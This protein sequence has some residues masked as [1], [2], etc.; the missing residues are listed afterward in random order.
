MRG[1]DGCLGAQ[2]CGPYELNER[3]ALKTSGE[4]LVL[5]TQEM[6]QVMGKRRTFLELVQAQSSIDIYTKL[7]MRKHRSACEA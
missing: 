1:G 2:Q 7:K 3:N 5:L 4:N 6:A